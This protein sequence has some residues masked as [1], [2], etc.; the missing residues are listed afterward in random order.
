VPLEDPQAARVVSTPSVAPAVGCHDIGVFIELKKAAAACLTEGQ[1]WDISDPVNPVVEHHIANPLVNIWHSGGFTWDGEVA[2]FGDE[3][4]GAVATHGCGVTPPGAAWF[5]DPENPRLPLGFFEQQRAQAPQSDL[6]CTTHN[7][8][9]VPTTAGYFLNSAF[10]EA[11]TGIVDF[12]EVKNRE[13]DDPSSVQPVGEEIAYYDPENADGRDEGET[14][15][16]YWYKGYTYGND[17]NRGVDVFR[18]TGDA[19]A[20][21][22]SLHH[23]NPQ[24]QENVLT[25]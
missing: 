3:E 1:I 18:Y 16:S 23:L 24:T 19:I 11:G 9:A 12:S 17:M 4:G 22:R 20:G 5:Y 25:E 7:Y 13:P 14:W 8:N 15:S 6:I 10:Y 2:I 21:D